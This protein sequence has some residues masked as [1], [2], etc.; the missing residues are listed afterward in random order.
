MATML[1]DATQQN[2]CYSLDRIEQQ[3]CNPQTVCYSIMIHSTLTQ[4][5]S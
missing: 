2:R 4:S 5:Q 3:Q 1:K